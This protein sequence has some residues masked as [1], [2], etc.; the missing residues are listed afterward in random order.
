MKCR[1]YS[2]AQARYGAIDLAAKRWPGEAKWMAVLDVPDAIGRRWI[3]AA[4]GKPT[5]RIYANRD[6]HGPL[7][8]VFRLLRER[9]LVGE[10]KT[11]DGCFNIRQVRGYGRVS[12]HAYGLGID[13]NAAE[14]PLGGVPR[15][16]AAFVRCWLDAGFDW[17][18]RF[19]T[20]R[21]PMHFSYAWEG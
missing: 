2:A 15:L 7:L 6:M 8:E 9:G 19:K 18:G 3:N 13:I 1:S 5:T 21:D 11:F 10:L 17:G 4:T 14:N 20:R 16:S 12:T